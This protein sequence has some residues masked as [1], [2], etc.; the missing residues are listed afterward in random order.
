M[1]LNQTQLIE[2]IRIRVTELDDVYETYVK[3]E[4]FFRFH[5]EEYLSLLR[6]LLAVLPDP[7]RD[8]PKNPPESEVKGWGG[9]PDH[10]FHYD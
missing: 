10:P 8:S 5:G 1:V 6:R 4:D 7:L 9:T 3:D 2:A